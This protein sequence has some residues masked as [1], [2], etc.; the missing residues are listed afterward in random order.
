MQFGELPYND[1]ILDKHVF[2]ITNLSKDTGYKPTM[3]YE[4]T[5]KD[6]HTYLTQECLY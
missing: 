1:I 2:S 3:T 5:V 4:Q 6:L